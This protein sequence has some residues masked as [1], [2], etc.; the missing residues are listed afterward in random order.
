MREAC[1]SLTEQLELDTLRLRAVT[2]NSDVKQFIED[3]EVLCVLEMN[4]DGQMHKLLQLE[5]PERATR[6]RSLTQNNGL[7]LT[8]RWIAESLV[9]LV[10]G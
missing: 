7:P 1:D 6:L 8:A 5:V 10:G 2:F 4:T 9:D 3:H